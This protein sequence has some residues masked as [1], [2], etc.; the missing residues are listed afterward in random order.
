[1]P[2]SHE[3]APVAWSV[4]DVFEAAAALGAVLSTEEAE[5]FLAEIEGELMQDVLEAGRDL[6]FVR[7]RDVLKERDGHA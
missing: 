6:I 5:E 1:M 2:A 4:D 7:L 3:F